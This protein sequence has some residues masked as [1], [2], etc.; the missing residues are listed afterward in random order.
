MKEKMTHELLNN[1][2]M[3]FC[4]Y[5]TAKDIREIGKNNKGFIKKML[6]VNLT[7]AF[8]NFKNL[9]AYNRLLNQITRYSVGKEITCTVTYNANDHEFR[10]YETY[11]TNTTRYRE[12]YKSCESTYKKHYEQKL[13]KSK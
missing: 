13:G 12:S 6:H 1:E 2:N 5:I 8:Y 7:R 3:D 10:D 9:F 4:D 11:N